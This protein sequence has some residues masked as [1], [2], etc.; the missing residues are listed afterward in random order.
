M[1]FVA[2]AVNIPKGGNLL[3]E[4]AWTHVLMVDDGENGGP[5]EQSYG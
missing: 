2:L 3:T 4:A 1:R 5:S